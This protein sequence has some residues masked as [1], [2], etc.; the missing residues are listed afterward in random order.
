MKTKLFTILAVIVLLRAA[1]VQAVPNWDIYSDTDIYS[2]KYGLINIYDTPPEHTTVNMYG[3]SADYIGTHDSSTLNMYGGQADVRVWDTS[4]INISGGVLS[5][6]ETWQ[7]GEM[8]ISGSS[9]VGAIGV[10]NFGIVDMYAGVVN[11]IA[12]LESG[13]VNIYGG[14]LIEWINIIDTGEV[15]VYGHDLVKTNSGGAYGYGQ[16]YGYL[17]DETYIFVDLANSE[18]YD[19]INLIPEPTT[20]I[21][22]ALATL[23]IRRKNRNWQSF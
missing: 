17:M 3:G 23:F 9:Q 20:F 1:N 8:N 13:E 11:R 21:L 7:Y 19:H 18:A 22:L 15:N 10:R 2:G 16:L 4:V 14:Q 6:A 12:V 5:L